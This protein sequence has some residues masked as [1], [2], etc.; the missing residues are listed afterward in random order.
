MEPIDLG[1]LV[2]SAGD[3]IVAA[4]TDGSILLWYLP[5]SEFSDTPK[6]KRSANLST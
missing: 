2:Q 4:G 5:P 6:R 3:A 1:A